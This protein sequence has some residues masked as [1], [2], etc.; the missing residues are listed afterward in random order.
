MHI[1]FY[2]SKQ[3]MLQIQ[4]LGKQQDCSYYDLTYFDRIRLFRF[5]RHLSPEMLKR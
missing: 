2:Q 3:K 1:H 5:V 4:N